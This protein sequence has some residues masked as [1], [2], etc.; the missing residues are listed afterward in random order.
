MTVKPDQ[1]C[2]N[3]FTVLFTCNLEILFCSECLLFSYYAQNMTYVTCACIY[4]YI[5]K[6]VNMHTTSE[7]SDIHKAG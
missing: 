2:S 3:R 5:Y 7:S 1:V 6:A 4:R